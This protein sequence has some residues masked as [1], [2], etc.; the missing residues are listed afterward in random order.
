MDEA[1]KEPT[2][3]DNEDDKMEM[4]MERMSQ[5]RDELFTAAKK[6]ILKSQK[7]QKQEYDKRHQIKVG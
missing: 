1:N 5:I 4:Y 6:S 3:D 2:G 7:K